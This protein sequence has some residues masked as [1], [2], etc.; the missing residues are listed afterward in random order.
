MSANLGPESNKIVV[1]K[2]EER[3]MKLSAGI[4]KPKYSPAAEDDASRYQI[5][6]DFKACKLLVGDPMELHFNIYSAEKKE[7]L[8]EDYIIYL[9]SAGF[10]SSLEVLDQLKVVFADLTSMEMLTSL[11]L[12][13]RLYR[14]GKLNVE[15][16]KTKDVT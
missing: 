15:E 6:F 16:S 8:Y 7:Y 3:K 12:V 11:F 14:V 5:Y 4:D 2:I 1:E 10:P 13:C 9:T